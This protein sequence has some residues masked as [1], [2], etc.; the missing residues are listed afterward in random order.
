MQLYD[1]ALSPFAA[2]VR[3][4]VYAKALALPRA[5]PPGGLGSDEYRKINPIGKIPALV[6]DDGSVLPE[7]ILI[8]E[9]LEDRFPEPS[10][11]P[12]APAARARMRLI[13]HFAD[14]YAEPPLHALF[15]HVTDPTVRDPQVIAERFAELDVRYDQ[16]AGFLDARGPYAG[17]PALTLADC[18]LF[19]LFFFATRVQPLLG[20]ADPTASRP[21]LAAWWQRVREHPAVAKVDAEL[22]Q[23]LAEMMSK[24]P[25]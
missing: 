12:E 2:R 1:L 8:G 25:G 11:R 21:V 23:A 14:S 20:G 15:P 6:L 24:T 3:I 18:T 22:A 5:E 19:P 10:L 4:Q 9:Y 7:S 17:G 16:L 13:S